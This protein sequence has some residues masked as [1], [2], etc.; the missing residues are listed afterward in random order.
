M[1][2]PFALLAGVLLLAGCSATDPTAPAPTAPD[3]S[4]AHGSTGC[5]VATT[6]TA[7]TPGAA[8]VAL[9]CSSG[10]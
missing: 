4:F 1:I 8:A 5:P 7:G 3:P 6:A 2:K 9:V 10:Q